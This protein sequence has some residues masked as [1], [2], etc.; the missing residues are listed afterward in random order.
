M[1]G[2]NAVLEE[3]LSAEMRF[4][5]RLVLNFCFPNGDGRSGR[6]G[7]EP[8]STV[9]RRPADARHDRR[10]EQLGRDGASGALPLPI[11]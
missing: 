9:H 6:P 1:T 10:A 11:P 8:T 5:R 7:G 2:G 3:G 4:Y